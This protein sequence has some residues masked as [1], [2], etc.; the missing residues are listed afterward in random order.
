MKPIA[1]AMWNDFHA[2]QN[3]EWLW[4]VTIKRDHLE[5]WAKKEIADGRSIKRFQ[6]WEA[7]KV[8]AKEQGKT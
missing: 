7:R 1:T 8:A 3:E 5:D 6:T 4:A 2:Y